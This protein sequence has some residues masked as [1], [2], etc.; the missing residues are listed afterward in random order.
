MPSR[1]SRFLHLERSRGERPKSEEPSHL[2]SSGRFEEMVERREGVDAT[3]VPEAHVERFK[4][5]GE[6]PL[7]LA[8]PPQEGPRFPRCARCEADNGRYAQECTACGA[9]LTTPEQREYTER[10]WQERRLREREAQRAQEQARQQ[11]EAQRKAEEARRAEQLSQLFLKQGEGSWLRYVLEQPSIGLGLL[12]LIPHLAV[13]W[14]VLVGA[15]VVPLLLMRWGSSSVQGAGAIM[16][17]F[18]ILLVLPRSWFR[19]SG[20][21]RR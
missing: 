16:L 12:A 7:A 13:R 1:F 3:L 18:V 15:L 4:L 20:M 5:H 9:D 21:W 14:A 10:Y 8:E 2:Q 11:W 6:T 17:L 19:R